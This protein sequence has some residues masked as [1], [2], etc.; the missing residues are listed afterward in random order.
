MKKLTVLLILVT[1][2]LMVTAGGKSTNY[3]TANG[4]TYFCETVL[5]GILHM[6]I[7]L[8]DGSMLKV[9]FKNI[10]AYC[11]NGHLYERLPVVCKN[12][13]ANCTAL[14]EYVSSRNGFRLYKYCKS[15]SCGELID[16]TYESGKLHTMFFVFKDGKF[17]IPVTK[18][19][20]ESVLPFFG[21]KVI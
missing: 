10:D 12:A 5:P 19:N 15:G 17:F 20:V 4:K 13:P 14:M 7:T 11:N 16:N 2:S 6:R 18:E 21:V 3:V 9:P 1:I 8:D